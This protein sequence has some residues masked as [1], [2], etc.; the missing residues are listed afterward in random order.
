VRLNLF[1]KGLKNMWTKL[2]AKISASL[3]GRFLK[4]TI[5]KGVI[6]LAGLVLTFGV[7]KFPSESQQ[8]SDFLI[9]NAETIADAITNIINTLIGLI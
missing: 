3:I 1:I 2:K 8:L 9:A 5:K 7:G 4:P 6:L